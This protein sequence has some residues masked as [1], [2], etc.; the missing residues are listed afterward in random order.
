MDTNSNSSYKNSVYCKTQNVL[1]F[2]K[3][4]KVAKKTHT[5]LGEWNNEQNDCMH[6]CVT[7][8]HFGDFMWGTFH[9]YVTPYAERKQT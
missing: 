7:Q 3:L 9:F 2:G 4:K 6:D 1:E 5:W 8:F